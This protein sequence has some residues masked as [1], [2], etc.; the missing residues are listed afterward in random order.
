MPAEF[1]KRD[2]CGELLRQVLLDYMRAS[3]VVGWPGA[4]GLTD[5]DILNCYPRAISAGDVPAWHELQGRFPELVGELQALREAKGWLE[6]WPTVL[7][8][9]HGPE[10][11]VGD[12]GDCRLSRWL[13]SFASE[14]GWYRVGEFIA[15]DAA[16]AIERAVDVFGPGA[17]YLAEQIPWDAAPLSKNL[18]TACN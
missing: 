2:T 7:A 13:V 5:D 10:P 15:L 18:P 14:S 11:N 1:N 3:R 16:A 6:T 4:D 9:E 17:A 8:N 12:T